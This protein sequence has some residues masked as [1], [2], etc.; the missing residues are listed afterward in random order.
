MYTGDVEEQIRQKFERL[1]PFSD[2]KM[3][4]LMAANEA[5]ALGYGGIAMV[6][7]ASGLSQP[8]IRAGLAELADPRLVVQGRVRRSGGGRK[9][10]TAGDPTILGDLDRLISPRDAGGSRKPVAVDLQEHRQIGGR[11]AE[12]RSSD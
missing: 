3:R 2:E 11:T 1:R 8:T 9:S 10:V 6:S 4:R 12:P 7:R 5:L